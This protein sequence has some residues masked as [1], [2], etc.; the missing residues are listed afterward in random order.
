ML[1]EVGE[2]VDEAG[3]E[4][5]PGADADGAPAGEGG[6]DSGGGSVNVGGED[7]AATTS[8]TKIGEL[9]K[10]DR[11]GERRRCGKRE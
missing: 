9:R 1:G 2:D 4:V 6:V 8:A 3:G 7:G 11:R 10:R 5:C